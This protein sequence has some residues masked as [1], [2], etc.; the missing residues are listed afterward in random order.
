MDA[1]KAQPKGKSG[2]ADKALTFI[3]KLYAAETECRDK[4]SA[5]R[6]ERRQEDSKQ[7]LAEFKSW[8]DDA[9]QKVAPK[10]TLGKAINYTL[11]YWKELNAYISS[12]QFP[13]D[14][15]LVEN[16]IRPFVVG[17]KAWLF[18]CRSSDLI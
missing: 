14:N 18:S 5:L 10:N 12:G 17:R 15:N 2:R 6:Y 8:L 3:R 11:N 7:V 9:Q 16:A 4:T 1:K 13:I